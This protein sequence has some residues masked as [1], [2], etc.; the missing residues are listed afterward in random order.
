MVGSQ[1]KTGRRS[2]DTQSSQ[3]GAAKKIH[4]KEFAQRM[5]Q[6]CD[7][8]PH[9]PPLHHGRLVWVVNQLQTRFGTKVSTE[10]VRKW[11]A[12]ESFPRVE[13]LHQLAE[14]FGVDEGWL[15]LGQAPDLKPAERKARNAQVSGIVNVLAGVIEIEGGKPAF[16]DCKREKADLFAIIK[17]AHYT[18]RVVLGT[19]A[20]AL[21]EFKVPPDTGDQFVVGVVIQPNFTFDFYEIDA[22]TIANGTRRGGH[23]E[24]SGDHRTLRRIKTFA[25]RP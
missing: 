4:H 15:A 12:G 23:I 19:E 10:T 14:V 18:F 17:G 7:G 24:V 21:I 11:F 9:V 22:E 5:E 25:D 13:K 3:A 16:P 8:N 1:E 6:A 2:G 20:G